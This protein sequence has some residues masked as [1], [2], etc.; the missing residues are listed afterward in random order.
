[1]VELAVGWL[2]SHLFDRS[3]AQEAA[4]AVE[5]QL[6]GLAGLVRAKLDDDPALRTLE[7][8]AQSSP[9]PS[10]GTRRRVVQAL[11]DAVWTDPQF[12]EALAELVARL[13]PVMPHP[14]E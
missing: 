11:E 9:A 6:R 13:R 8:E 1:M 10:A 14:A 2:A 3:R 5:E 4:P 7:R 12:G